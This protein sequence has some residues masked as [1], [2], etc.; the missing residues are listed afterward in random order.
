MFSY[1]GYHAN[2]SNKKWHLKDAK[3]TLKG[4]LFSSEG[5]VILRLSVDNSIKEIPLE[6]FPMEDKLIIIEIMALEEKFNNASKRVVHLK[7]KHFYFALALFQLFV[8]VFV[9]QGGFEPPTLRAE[10]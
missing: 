2:S 8:D 1:S 6:S 5:M 10:I 9:T 3:T 4:D 7:S